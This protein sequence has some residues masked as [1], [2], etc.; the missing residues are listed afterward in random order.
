MIHPLLPKI[1]PRFMLAR[2]NS[3]EK[4]VVSAKKQ[5]LPDLNRLT[6]ALA[7]PA[8]WKMLRE[9]TCGEARSIVELAAVAGVRYENAVKH[10]GVLRA[11][12]LVVQGRGSLY[13][14]QP[15]HLPQAGVAEVDFGHCLLRLDADNRT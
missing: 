5:P 12:G 11:A 15:H 4:A 8:R 14:L 1:Q 9:L 7:Q 10:L 2:M 3:P 6:R 13:Q